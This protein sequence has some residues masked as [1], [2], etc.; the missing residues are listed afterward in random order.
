MGASPV[1]LGLGFARQK[2]KIEA[3]PKGNPILKV[4]AALSPSESRL[5][6]DLNQTL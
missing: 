2:F 5:L 6:S 1:A 4:D 3:T